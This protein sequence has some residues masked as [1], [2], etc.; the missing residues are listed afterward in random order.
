M[1]SFIAGALPSGWVGG[2]GEDMGARG[3]KRKLGADMGGEGDARGMPI[4]RGGGGGGGAAG[5]A[6]AAVA[7]NRPPAFDIYRMRQQQRRTVG[8]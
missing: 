8:K 5:G 7:Q 1:F 6:P 4:Q 2:A 3:A